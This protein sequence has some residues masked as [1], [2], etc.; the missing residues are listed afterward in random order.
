MEEGL[1]KCEP[2][3][4]ENL[5]TIYSYLEKLDILELETFSRI[6]TLI[7]NNNILLHISTI[8]RYIQAHSNLMFKLKKYY[9]SK[10]SEESQK[11]RAEALVRKL[12]REFWEDIIFVI[13]PRLNEFKVK[14]IKILL[15]S[16][17]RPKMGSRSN[18]RYN[19]FGDF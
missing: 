5:I 6:E 4:I 19:L 10:A 11:S 7:M 1:V 8:T 15:R 9:I 2:E 14:E 3:K 16:A 13:G 12:N 18:Q 17:S